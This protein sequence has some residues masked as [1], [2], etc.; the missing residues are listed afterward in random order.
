MRIVM[1]VYN[2]VR[3]DARVL[4]EARA[5]SEAGH[6]V[7]VIGRPAD[8]AAQAQEREE[9]DAFSILRVPVPGGWR[10]A[11]TF[12]RYPW[13]LRR[14]VAGRVARGVRRLPAGIRD[15]GVGL[16]AGVGIGLWSFVSAPIYLLGRRRGRTPG[17]GTL[18][19]LVR[20]RWATI[21]WAH[22]AARAA[23]QAEVYHGHDLSGLPAAAESASRHSA[24]LVYDSHEYFI[25]SGSNARRPGWA[26]KFSRATSEGWPGARMDW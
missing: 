21:G 5:L 16:A 4:R 25:E 3:R 9:L 15:V 19:W 12:L 23:P 10:M 20:W 17:G 26:K 6:D 2:D 14:L 13:R 11:W 1:F 24:R 7:T 18:D 22:R 8:P